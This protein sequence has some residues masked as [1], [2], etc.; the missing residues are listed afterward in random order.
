MTKP[1]IQSQVSLKLLNTFGVEAKAKF[2]CQIRHLDDIQNILQ[3]P[4]FKDIP[5]LI[6]G[7]GSNLLLTQ[8]FEGLVLQMDIQGIEK[9]QETQDCVLLRFGAGVNWHSAV[10]Y[11]I[12]K[13]LGGLENLSLIPGT[14]GAAPIQNIGAYGVEL[15]D[16][17]ESLEAVEI[18]TG[19]CQ[20]FT[21]SDCKFGYRNSI[22]KQELKGKFIITSVVLRLSKNPKFTIS[23]GAIQS[24]LESYD[25]DISLKTIS[26]AI[27]EIRQN[28]LPDPAKIGNSGSF[29]KNP[30]IPNTQFES[31]KNQFPSIIGY[32]VS[33]SKTKIPAG[34]LIEQTGIKGKHFGNTGT[35]EKQALVLVN[36]GQATGKEI[37]DFSKKVQ[38]FVFEKFGIQLER[39]VNV[40]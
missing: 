31:L 34:W 22:F 29:F 13:E 39:E 17:F 5:F 27:I 32:A 4:T 18:A 20:T 16:V 6:L 30:T 33:E 9:I 40:I 11:T 7:G 36:H 15:K 19:K 10:C 38:R 28:K 3:N 21:S 24:K 14:I 25:Q 23:Y 26:N 8:D 35:Y 37:L 1:H 2:F 12:E